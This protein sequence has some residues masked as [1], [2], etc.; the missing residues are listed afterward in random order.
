MFGLFIPCGAYAADL[1]STVCCWP[2]IAAYAAIDCFF[3]RNT[4]YLRVEDS[5]SSETR[6]R[7]HVPHLLYLYAYIF[8]RTVQ[9]LDGFL[10]SLQFVVCFENRNQ[11]VSEILLNSKHFNTF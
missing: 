3:L 9:Q 5:I 4:K 2:I 1:A 11:T 7:V 6:F 10:Q 8:R